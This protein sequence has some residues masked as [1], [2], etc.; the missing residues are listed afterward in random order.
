MTDIKKAYDA[1]RLIKEGVDQFYSYN[2]KYNL[3]KLLDCHELLLT[4][5]APFKI[6]DKVVLTKTPDINEKDSW[7]WMHARHFLIKGAKGIVVEFDVSKRGFSAGVL[8]EEESWIDH[9]GV[10]TL[11]KPVERH[12]YW[13]HEDSLVRVN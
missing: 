12:Q 9:R 1:I 13:F 11:Y 10:L 8:F 6:N 4:K 3:D 2:F 7:G 5:Y